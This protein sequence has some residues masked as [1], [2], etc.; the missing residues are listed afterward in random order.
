MATAGIE[1][2]L[3]LFF[4]ETA[5]VFDYLGADATLVLHGDMEAAFSRFWQDTRD[6]Y[7]LLQGDPERPILAPQA[8][9]LDA[10]QFY[11]LRQCPCPAGPAHAAQ[12]DGA[13]VEDAQN[14][15]RSLPPLTVVRG[16][17]DP[18]TQLKQHIDDHARTACW[19]WPKATAGAKA[20]ST[21][22]APAAWSRCAS[23]PCRNSSPARRRSAWPP[24]P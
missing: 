8:L 14:D 21:S 24:A 5:T 20:C 23:T 16:A 3:P 6:R 17:E 1:Y 9:F 7:R 19:C 13:Q 15:W 4:E 22:C 10:E 2:Y 18:L 12:A 11:T